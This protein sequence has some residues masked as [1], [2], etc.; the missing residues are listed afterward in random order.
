MGMLNRMKSWQCVPKST[1]SICKA[2][3]KNSPQGVTCT[4][5]RSIFQVNVCFRENGIFLK[6][7]V[8][9]MFYLLLWGDIVGYKV[10]MLTWLW[11]LYFAANETFICGQIGSPA[12]CLRHLLCTVLVSQLLLYLQKPELNTVLYVLI[13]C[14]VFCRN[15]E[16]NQKSVEKIHLRWTEHDRQVETG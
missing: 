8:F 3:F 13:F 10:A 9:Q 14:S 7:K 4:A 12:C 6:I 15:I 2:L 1:K 11:S 16:I 5:Y